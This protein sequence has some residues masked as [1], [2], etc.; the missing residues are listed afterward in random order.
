MMST[1]LPA[2]FFFDYLVTS[3][4]SR[5]VRRQPKFPEKKFQQG[6]I[7]IIPFPY[8]Q[9]S[10]KTP[11]QV[12]RIYNVF[13][14]I[15]CYIFSANESGCSNKFMETQPNVFLGCQHPVAHDNRLEM[16]KAGRGK[17]PNQCRLVV[18]LREILDQDI[19]NKVQ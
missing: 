11:V 6:E 16:I 13:S 8:I 2:C 1:Y 9:R 15:T 5:T 19:I 18:L 4:L 3:L 14:F 12:I 10:P 7:S 17:Q